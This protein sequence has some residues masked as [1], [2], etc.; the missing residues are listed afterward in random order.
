MAVLREEEPLTRILTPVLFPKVNAVI[1]IV[2]ANVN[3]LPPRLKGTD[4]RELKDV[5]VIPVCRINKVSAN[6][7]FIFPSV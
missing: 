5:V 3:W 2:C 1:D 7:P 4:Y 6:R